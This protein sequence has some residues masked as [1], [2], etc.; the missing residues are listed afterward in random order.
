M[1]SLEPPGETL[2]P[3]TTLGR[4]ELRR[5]IGRGGM[6][7]V[8]EAIHRDLKKRVAVKTLLP[9]LAANPEA[10]ARFLREG[11]AASRIRHPNVVD[12]TDMGEEGSVIYLVMELLQGEDLAAAIQRQ[13][14]LPI[15]QTADVLLPVLAAIA[16]AHERGVVHRDLKPENIFLARSEY[17][18]L[19]P[20][21]LD[22]GISKVV[23]AAQRAALT[24]TAV[25]LGTAFYLPPEQLRGSRQ[26]DARGDQYA[27]GAILYEC[28]TGRRAFDGDSLYAVLKAVGD[29]IYTPPRV[30][31]A[32]LPAALEATIAR[33][34]DARPGARFPSVWDLG[35]ALLPFASPPV[36]LMWRGFFAAAPPGENA[37]GAAAAPAV[38]AAPAAAAA[39]APVVAAAVAAPAASVG[40]GTPSP[41]EVAAALGKPAWRNPALAGLVAALLA[42]LLVVALRRP[43]EGKS[44]QA[45]AAQTLPAATVATVAPA[46]KPEPLRPVTAPAATPDA[47]AA[48]TTAAPTTAEPTATTAAIGVPAPAAD[49]APARPR[50]AHPATSG[51]P[52]AGATEGNAGPSRPGNH[53][54]PNKAPIV[55]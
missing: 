28:V 19:V 18:A 46:A 47:S 9:A 50:R 15:A 48:P 35:A 38:A 53:M 24:G 29:G 14:P 55:E 49:A 44:Q 20:K 22:F 13:G 12:V 36:E 2:P 5:L 41:D 10:K 40:A 7:A 26:A 52:P 23:D 54:L 34:L 11:E 21:V 39:A 51:Q 8:Y 30:L 4:Y 37:T 25:T 43:R 17:G 33:A 3:G 6:G 45:T 42:V 31:R 16:S 1:S 32:D 27:L